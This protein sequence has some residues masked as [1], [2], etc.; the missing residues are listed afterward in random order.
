MVSCQMNETARKCS[1]NPMSLVC[2]LA[3]DEAGLVEL[4]AQNGQVQLCMPFP[5]TKFLAKILSPLP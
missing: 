1:G 3:S 5:K 4:S 2:V